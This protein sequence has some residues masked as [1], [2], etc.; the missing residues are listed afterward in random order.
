MVPRIKAVP[1]AKAAIDKAL[2]L[3]NSLA[4]AHYWLAC[5]EAWSEWDWESAEIEFLQAFKLN[6]NYPDTH[7]Y[8]SHLLAQ[9]GR[10]EEAMIYMERALELDPLNP[11]FHGMY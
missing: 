10:T 9:M 1:L 7:A 5:I 6:P 2:E 3:D 8:Y 4:E 11:L